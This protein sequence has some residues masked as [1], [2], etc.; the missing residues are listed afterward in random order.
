[1]SGQADLREIPLSASTLGAGSLN[2]H[3]LHFTSGTRDGRWYD[4]TANT[5]TSVTIDL[6]G[7]DLTGVVIGDSVTITEYWTLDTLFP[8]AQATTGWTE[9]PQNAGTFIQNGHAIV[10]S[11]GAL[12][13]Q[14]R[15]LLLFPDISGEGTNR[16]S[17][18][19]YY[20]TANQW[21]AIGNAEDDQGSNI[22]YPDM[23]VSIRHPVSVTHPTVLRTSGEVLTDNFSIPLASLTTGQHD[24]FV[25]LPRPVDVSLSDLNLWESG[26]FV[27][28]L[29]VLPFQRRD[30]ILVYNNTQIATN[31]APTATYYHNGSNWLMIGS[32]DNKDGELIPAGSGFIV[33]RYQSAT[34][35]TTV[36]NNAAT[37]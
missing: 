13:F 14:R 33:R 35:V 31:K 15:T 3:Y 32:S 28:S 17:I 16:A 4:I 10:A 9:D 25:A 7:D 6:N 11:T 18:L 8:P 24:N 1:V 29:G 20:I 27:Q 34:G 37:Y 19:S 21:Y 30:L 12:P 26:A 22:L 2:Q 36:W 23:M 5:T